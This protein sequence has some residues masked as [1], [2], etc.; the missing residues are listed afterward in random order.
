MLKNLPNTPQDIIAWTWPAIE[1]YYQ[2][3]EARSLKAS[4]VDDWLADWSSVGE[5]LE[6]MYSR[7]SVA[8]TVNTADKEADAR[9]NAFLDGIFPN[10]M[11]AEQKL[12]EKLL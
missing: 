10:V 7:L 3:L 11:A 2:E 4:D 8:T 9:M 1:P 6:E 12:K 5:R